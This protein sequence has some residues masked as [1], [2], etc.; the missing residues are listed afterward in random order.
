MEEQMTEEECIFLGSEAEQ[1]VSSTLGVYL[2]RCADRQ[3]KAAM[4]RLTTVSPTDSDEI[5]LLQNEVN[6]MDD[7]ERW[8]LDAIHIGM[9]SYSKIE[10]EYGQEHL[11]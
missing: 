10:E 2:L 4:K 3:S 6:R 7:F 9:A 11:N 8:L 1:F 5:L